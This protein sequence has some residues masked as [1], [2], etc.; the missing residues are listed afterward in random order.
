M[1]TSSKPKK[2]VPKGQVRE[3]KLVH[4]V[5]RKGADIIKTEEVK[6]PKKKV[7]S[8]SRSS[9]PVKRRRVDSTVQEPIPLVFEV[10]DIS[11]KRRTLVRLF[12]CFDSSFFLIH[13]IQDQNDYLRQFLDHEK[14]YLRLLIGQEIPPSNSI[15]VSC[16]VQGA[17]FRCLDCFGPHWWCKACLIDSHAWQPFHQPQRWKNGSFEKV[18]LY[19]LGVVLNLGGCCCTKDGSPFGDRAITVIHINGVFTTSVRF[20]HCPGAAADHEQLFANRLFPSTFDRPSTAFTFQLLDYFAIDAMECKTSAQSF[21]QKLRRM[22]NNAF[23][24]EVPVSW[25]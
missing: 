23:P 13:G 15:C 10:P 14:T 21:F 1:S 3:L 4:S 6:T 24:D 18:S 22:T 9:S 5:S 12:F 7:A 16:N 2:I 20:C 17:E 25:L 11:K 19:E 8:K